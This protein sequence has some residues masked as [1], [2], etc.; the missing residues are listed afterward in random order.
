MRCDACD[1]SLH[2]HRYA[3][4]RVTPIIRQCVTSVTGAKRVCEEEQDWTAIT[5]KQVAGKSIYHRPMLAGT[6]RKANRVTAE[7]KSESDQMVGDH[8]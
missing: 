8:G 2:L 7:L 3:R 1:A 6:K 4:A 5:R